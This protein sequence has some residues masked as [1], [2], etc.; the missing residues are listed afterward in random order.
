LAVG[1]ELEVLS[2]DL[3]TYLRG[4]Q[5][6]LEKNDIEQAIRCLNDMRKEVD[7]NLEF[8]THVYV[9]APRPSAGGS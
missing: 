8:L 5:A 7:E 6:A 4:F 1:S 3:E 2:E 9:G